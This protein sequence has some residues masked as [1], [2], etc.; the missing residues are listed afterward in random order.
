MKPVAY[1]GQVLPGAG[2]KTPAF[3]TLKFAYKNL[4]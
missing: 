4:K 1:Q 2:H 3:S